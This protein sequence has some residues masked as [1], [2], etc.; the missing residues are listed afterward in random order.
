MEFA[1]REQLCGGRRG[2]EVDE[3]KGCRR[4]GVNV[5]VKGREKCEGGRRRGRWRR[6]GARWMMELGGGGGDGKV[7]E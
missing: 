2:G 1:G 6:K 4:K 3:G 5:E 7:E